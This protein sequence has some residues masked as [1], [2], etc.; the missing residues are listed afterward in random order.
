L[1]PGILPGALC[2]RYKRI[3]KTVSPATAIAMPAATLAIAPAERVG[4]VDELRLRN[5][6]G[7]NVTDAFEEIEEHDDDSTLFL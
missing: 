1:S 5:G 3:S 7:L 6:A 2:R 4:T